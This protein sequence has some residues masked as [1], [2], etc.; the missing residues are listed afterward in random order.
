MSLE[1][2]ITRLNSATRAMKAITTDGLEQQLQDAMGTP[3]LVVK[4]L[5][6]IYGI[7]AQELLPTVRG[8]LGRNYFASGLKIDNG[9]LYAKSVTQA[10]IR[11]NAG[12]SLIIVEMGTGGDKH[13]Y[14][15]AGAFRFGGVRNMQFKTHYTDL[16]TGERKQYKGG[17]GGVIGAKQKRTIKALA[18]GTKRAGLLWQ[19]QH[20]EER[21]KAVNASYII[22]QPRP[23]FFSLDNAIDEIEQ[24][25]AELVQREIDAF[26]GKK[27]EAA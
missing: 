20:N 26:L 17:Q 14:G 5:K 19:K 9:Q 21:Q 16:I 11:I 1:Q 12:A 3:D 13:V 7:A 22:I 2:S 15:R 25:F 8:V 24:K 27:A 23:P 4:E 18:F 10:T 6:R